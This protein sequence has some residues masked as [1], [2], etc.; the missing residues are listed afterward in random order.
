MLMGSGGEIPAGSG[1]AQ[2]TDQARGVPAPAAH[3]RYFV[4]VA[5]DY[6]SDR[7]GSA[8]LSGRLAA[9]SQIFAHPIDRE[10]EVE[11]VIHHGFAAVFHLPGLRG[12]FRDHVEHELGVKARLEGEVEA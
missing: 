7:Q 8:V 12:A 5:R 10:S 2:P 1:S 9:D 6:L 4:V 11:L 3:L